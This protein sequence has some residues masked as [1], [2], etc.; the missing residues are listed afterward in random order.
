MAFLDLNKGPCST[1]S[2]QTHADGT[3]ADL[4]AGCATQVACTNNQPAM[5][6]ARLFVD[7]GQ[8]CGIINND[9]A[10]QKAVNA[11]FTSKFSYKPWHSTFMCSVSGHTHHFHV[12]VK[13]PD[14]TSN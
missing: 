2:H 7:T 4:T 8:V 12:R 6:L 14:G 5:D 9:T 1:V 11:Y 10:V 13:K 3:H